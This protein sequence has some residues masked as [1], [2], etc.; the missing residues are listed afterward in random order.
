MQEPFFRLRKGLSVRIADGQDTFS[1]CVNATTNAI[2][3]EQK[4]QGKHNGLSRH[5][6]LPISF[7]TARG[8]RLSGG[9]KHDVGHGSRHSSSQAIKTSRFYLVPFRDGCAFSKRGI[10]SQVFRAALGVTAGHPQSHSAAPLGVI[11]V[12]PLCDH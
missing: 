1:N 5:A 4:D 2:E 6:N 12:M 3:Q 8:L 9:C 10:R 7:E 11:D